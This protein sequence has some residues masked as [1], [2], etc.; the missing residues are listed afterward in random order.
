MNQVNLLGNICQDLEIKETSTGKKN[1]RFSIAIRRSK[2]ES[3]FINCTAWNKTAEMIAQYFK[4]SDSIAITGNIKTGMYEKDGVK[5]YT[6]DIW[7]EKFYFV[8]AGKKK[9]DNVESMGE[10]IE[11]DD[12]EEEFPF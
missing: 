3:D 12:L 5:K 11:S 6:T 10:V 8:G 1:I 2:D 4:K 7:I 9:N